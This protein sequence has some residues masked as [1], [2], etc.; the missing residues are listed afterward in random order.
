[1]VK[2][3]Y[4]SALVVYNIIIAI[5]MY[6]YYSKRRKGLVHIDFLG[7]TG[8]SMSCDCHNNALFWYGNASMALMC[9]NRLA[10]VWC[11]MIIMCHSRGVNLIGATE[12]RNA[13]SASPRSIR[14][15]PDPFLL[16]EVGSGHPMRLSDCVRELELH[17]VVC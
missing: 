11:H 16:L 13:M 8:C 3:S 7:C 17:A 9:S 12:F 10:I 2:F 6:C 15:V 14:C 5:Y 1:M 4:I